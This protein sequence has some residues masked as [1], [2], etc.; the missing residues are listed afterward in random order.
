M[1]RDEQIVGLYK[2]GDAAVAI[3]ERFNLTAR[4]VLRIVKKTGASRT[5]QESFI[6]AIERGRMRYPRINPSLKQ[7]RKKLSLATRLK[8]L[9]AANYRCVLCGASAGDGERIEVDHIDNNLAN[10]APINLQV[11]CS[12]CNKGKAWTSRT[13]Q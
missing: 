5:I 9:E 13:P 11:L 12:R 7:T 4:Q 3:G 10:N 8:I 2:A 1:D 6:L